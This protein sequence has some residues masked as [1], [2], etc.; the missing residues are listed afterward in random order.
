MYNYYKSLYLRTS[1]QLEEDSLSLRCVDN[2]FEPD[3]VC[4]V[5]SLGIRI[6]QN[7]EYDMA[8]KTASVQGILCFVGSKCVQTR[9]L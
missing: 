1:N 9:M 6:K 2:S 3:R 5:K 4:T 8:H 7:E